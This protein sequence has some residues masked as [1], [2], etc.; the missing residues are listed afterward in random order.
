MHQTAIPLT[1]VLEEALALWRE[2][3]SGDGAIGAA[4]TKARRAGRLLRAAEACYREMGTA[5]PSPCRLT[6]R[7]VEVLRL[8]AEGQ[9]DGEIADALAVS[10]RTVTTHVTGILG[11]LDVP[12]RSAAV[13]YGVRHG[14]A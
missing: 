13:A 4:A 9:T 11:K 5:A 14:L 10:R 12:S 6:P 2:L 3:E 1:I 7:E 8:I